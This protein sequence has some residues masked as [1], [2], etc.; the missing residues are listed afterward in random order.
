[1]IVPELTSESSPLLT[2]PIQ[3]EGGE[4]GGL[5]G[6]AVVAV[7]VSSVL[8]GGVLRLHRRDSGRAWPNPAERPS[9]GARWCG[10]GAG[11]SSGG[12]AG[13]AAG[14]NFEDAAENDPE[15]A[16]AL[17]LSL[18]EE[19]TRLEKERAEQ[20]GSTEEGQGGSSDKKDDDKMDTA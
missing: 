17:K 10:A 11:G 13:D 9:R 12:D 4:P 14:F 19:K 7:G 20:G 15:L 2:S 5:A 1:M 3:E 6:R 8:R 18:E 16:F